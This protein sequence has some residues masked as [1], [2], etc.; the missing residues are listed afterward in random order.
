MIFTEH[1]LQQISL[2]HIKIIWIKRILSRPY[3]QKSH[4]ID[5]ELSIIYGWIT[6][7]SKWL[8]IIVKFLHHD[9]V[10]ITAH[11]DRNFKGIVNK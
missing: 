8:K 1:A 10:I 9:V 6:E 2:R 4:S 7:E 5:D 3:L 11:F